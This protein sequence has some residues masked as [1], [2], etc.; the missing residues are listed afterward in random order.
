MTVRV[1]GTGTP[2]EVVRCLMKVTV[3]ASGGRILIKQVRA[4][5]GKVP[6][7]EWANKLVSL[8]A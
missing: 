5:E 3:Q 6:A 1:A 2:G 8:L 4:D 7:S